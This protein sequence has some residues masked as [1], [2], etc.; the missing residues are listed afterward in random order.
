M[1]KIQ[2][3]IF[4]LN[5]ITFLAGEQNVLHFTINVR[6]YVA[7]VCSSIISLPVKISSFQFQ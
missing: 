1:I 7:P 3:A 6:L 5:N 2:K 4:L